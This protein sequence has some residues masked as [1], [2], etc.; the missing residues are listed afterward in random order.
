VKSISG[1]GCLKERLVQVKYESSLG[2]YAIGASGAISYNG[3]EPFW[4]CSQCLPSLNILRILVALTRFT[5]GFGMPFPLKFAIRE[6]LSAYSNKEISLSEFEDWFFP[7]TWE[8]DQLDNFSLLN[9]VYGMK[10]RFAEFSNSDWTEDDLPHL[11]LGEF[12]R[13]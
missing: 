12:F 1:D 9:L 3:E 13:I 8:V 5:G 7:E 2:F 11:L 4:A 10:L 6:K